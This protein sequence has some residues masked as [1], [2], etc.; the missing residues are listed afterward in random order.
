MFAIVAMTVNAQNFEWTEQSSGVTEILRD[1]YFADSNVGWV[2]GNDGLILYT[3]DGGDQL[4][5]P[6][7]WRY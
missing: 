5:F 1:V 3:D 6:S 4:D 7:Q 2:V